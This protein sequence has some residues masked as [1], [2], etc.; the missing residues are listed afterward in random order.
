M[1]GYTHT[2]IAQ[3]I[4]LAFWLSSY[5]KG[6]ERD[7]E[8]LQEL[9]NRIN[10][11]PLGACALAGTTWN[12]DRELTAEFL[13]FNGVQV[14]ALDVVSSRGE[15]EAELLSILSILMLRLSR[16]AEELILFS[17][18]EFGFFE[19][20]DRYATGSS[21]MPQKKNPD[22]LELMRARCARIYGY[23]MQVLAT[24]KNLISGHN[25]DTQET[26]YAIFMAIDHSKASLAIL[27]GIIKTTKINKARMRNALERDFA[28]A[29]DL[30]DLLAKKGIPF[31]EAHSIAGSLVKKC[32]AKKMS[33]SELTP[34]MIKGVKLTSAEIKSSTD[35]LKIVQQRRTGP[36]PE[37]SRKM[38]QESERKM[39]ESQ[40]SLYERRK[41]IKQALRKFE[42][43]K[44][45]ISR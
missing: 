18:A 34:N 15:F 10:L 37:N 5:V 44:K 4:T 8:R 3:P 43:V 14:N 24:V 30:A 21:I 42:Q 25:A 1:P 36:A 23:L 45:S 6:F 28:S 17:S 26:K 19:L 13:G 11:N 9:Y 20:S 22:A 41:K 32:I 27:N 35:L 2:R 12:I 40:S 7:A 33:L 39:Q 16:I 29:T 38:L 31:R